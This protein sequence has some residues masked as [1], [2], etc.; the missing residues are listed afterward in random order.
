MSAPWYD[1]DRALDTNEQHISSLNRTPLV[2]ENGH[3]YRL[4]VRFFRG[5]FSSRLSN[6]FD[7]DEILA[8]QRV[9]QWRDKDG[10]LRVEA[11]DR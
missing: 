2:A 10:R 1:Y 8:S 11:R 5:D 6:V 7:I 9:E 3:R 4:V